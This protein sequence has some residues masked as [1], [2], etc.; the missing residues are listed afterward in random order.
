MPCG[1]RKTDSCTHEWTDTRSPICVEW[2]PLRRA[3]TLIPR[4]IAPRPHRNATFLSLHSTSEALRPICQTPYSSRHHPPASLPFA[5]H[6]DPPPIS[7]FPSR[8]PPAHQLLVCLF[9]CQVW[10][11]AGLLLYVPWLIK[12][13]NDIWHNSQEIRWTALAHLR[14][15]AG[16]DIKIKIDLVIFNSIKNIHIIVCVS[17]YL[18]IYLYI[19]AK[20]DTLYLSKVIKSLLIKCKWATLQYTLLMNERVVLYS[21]SRSVGPVLINSNHHHYSM[22]TTVL[23]ETPP[24]LSAS[25]VF[26]VCTVVLASPQKKGEATAKNNITA[27]EQQ[28]SDLW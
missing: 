15:S 6:S 19:V 16:S 13:R 14:L 24:M 17:I 25:S 8:P 20:L 26:I 3:S 11:T 28:L 23:D 9:K 18:F 4:P 5:K 21:R 22:D 27:G 1:V 10:V 12:H 2:R 7:L